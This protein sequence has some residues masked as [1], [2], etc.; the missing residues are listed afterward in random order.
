[1]KT[2]PQQPKTVTEAKSEAT[3]AAPLGSATRQQRKLPSHIE[4]EKWLATHDDILRDMKDGRY[5]TAVWAVWQ[6]AYL[7]G[8]WDGEKAAHPK[9]DEL[10][11]SLVSLAEWAETLLCNAERPKHCTDD[12]WRDI[13]KS[14]RDEMHGSHKSPNIVLGQQSVKTESTNQ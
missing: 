5:A 8:Q 3:L 1:M 4:C 12:E 13:L 2:D 10:Y 6:T 7:R 14:W 9:D 11:H